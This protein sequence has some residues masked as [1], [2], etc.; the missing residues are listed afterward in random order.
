V[1]Y[2]LEQNTAA[3]I[4]VLTPKSDGPPG[5]AFNVLHPC[6]AAAQPAVTSLL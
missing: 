5:F 6:N 1:L 4:Y 3:T 2:G